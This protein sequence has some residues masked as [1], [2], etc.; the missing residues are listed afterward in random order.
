M[1]AYEI[2]AKLENCGNVTYYDDGTPTKAE[3][4]TT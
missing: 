3:T 1:L 2:T 4:G